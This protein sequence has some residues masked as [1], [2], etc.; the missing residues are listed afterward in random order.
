MARKAATNAET[1]VTK[2]TTKKVESTTKETTKKTTTKKTAKKAETREVDSETVDKPVKKTTKK[3]SKKEVINVLADT[4]NNKKEVLSEIINEVI[5]ETLDEVFGDD[6]YL[7]DQPLDKFYDPDQMQLTLDGLASI[8][9]EVKQSIAFVNDEQIR[10]IIDSYYQTQAIRKA[11]ANQLRAFKQGKDNVDENQ[12]LAI[13]WLLKDSQNRENQI[14]K[15]ISE[16]VKSI[17][18]CEWVMK[19]KGIGPVIA[20]NLWSYI[21]MN[22]C[23]HANQFLSYAGM[24]DNNVP[25]IGKEKATKIVDEAYKYFGMESSDKVTEDVILRVTVATGRKNSDTVRNGFNNHREKAKSN[26]SDKQVLIKYLSMPPYNTQLKTLCFLIGDSFCKNSNRGSLYGRLYKE[27]KA[28]EIMKNENLEYKEQAERLLAEKTYTKG[29]DTYK[30]LIQGK[31]SPAHIDQRAKRW[32]VKIFLTHFFEACYIYTYNEKPPVI[33]PIAH[34]GHVDYIK[35][36]V[37]YDELYRK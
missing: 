15:M 25:W 8:S 32:A 31:L 26:T 27:R 18:L 5:D 13:E 11:T 4:E 35:P 36:E 28:L 30:C 17:P 14:K 33:F 20:A 23:R 6:E 16:Y 9:K 3:S 19:I 21:D 34:M 12:L 22:K 29:T 10:I 1:D 7:D 24:N 2:K 37:S